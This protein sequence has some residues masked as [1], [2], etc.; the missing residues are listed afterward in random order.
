MTGQSEPPKKQSGCRRSLEE[1]EGLFLENMKLVPYIA[2]NMAIKVTD[3]TIQDGYIGLWKASLAFDDSRD[4][5]FATFAAPV[6]RNSIIAAWRERTRT[7]D[8]DISL[9][10]SLLHDE[11]GDTEVRYADALVDW[12][13]ERSAEE[14]LLE[15]YLDARLTEQEKKIVLMRMNGKSQKV[16]GKAFGHSGYWANDRIKTIQRKLRKDFNVKG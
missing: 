4:L 9:E 3:D 2:N 12:N 16:I 6:I 15:M 14:L 10:Q 1:A 8:G 11:G 13:A 7:P 5:K